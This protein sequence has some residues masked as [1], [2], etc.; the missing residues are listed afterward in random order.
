MQL[1]FDLVKPCASHPEILVQTHLKVHFEV[2]LWFFLKIRLLYSTNFAE[3]WVKADDFSY[4]V[5]EF[6]ND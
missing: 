6:S 3:T 4:H 5:F 1:F 2:L